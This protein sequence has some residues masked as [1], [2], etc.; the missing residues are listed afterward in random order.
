[1][2]LLAPGARKMDVNV[3]L[4]FVDPCI[5]VQFIKKNPTTCNNVSK[6]YYSRFT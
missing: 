1:L 4:M 2:G 5:I 6:F 3:S